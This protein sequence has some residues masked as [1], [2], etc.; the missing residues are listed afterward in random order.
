MP[1]TMIRKSALFFMRYQDHPALDIGA[2]L[3]G[4]LSLAPKEG[5]VALSLLTGN[6]TPVS[7]DE[8]LVL[9]RIS[10]KD[11]V[12]LEET[13]KRLEIGRPVFTQLLERALLLDDGS[14]HQA[15][16]NKERSY[17]A[18]DWDDFAALYHI[19][20]R[21][22]DMD[23]GAPIRGA[24]LSTSGAG[25]T[26]EERVDEYSRLTTHMSASLASVREQFGPA[27]PPFHNRARTQ[28]RRELPLP[29]EKNQFIELLKQRKT[30]RIFDDINPL[31]EHE[32]STILYYTYGCQG[33]AELLPGVFG[34]RKTSPS[35]GSLHPIEAYP[36]VVNVA[37]VD[38]GLYHYNVEHHTLDLIRRMRPNQAADR[39]E[40]F[41]LGQSYFRT[42]NV[43][44][45]LTARW[46][47][48]FWKYRKAQKSYR[49]VYTDAGHLSQTLY[50]LCT[51]MKLGAFFTGAIN[52]INIEE[53]LGL[54]PLEEGV[55]GI[56]GCGRP[57]QG[58]SN[59]SLETL[60]YTPRKTTIRKGMTPQST[61]AFRELGS[62]RHRSKG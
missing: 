47:R 24:E 52:D 27:P 29:A 30:V 22:K 60:P 59:L 10:T 37:G 17:L 23:V 53:E 20:S 44:F 40:C 50:L 31:N 26:S 62:S 6:T 28:E 42:A 25:A 2:M 21:M 35:G 13:S 3:R 16:R 41:S 32:L 18:Q 12:S 43:L 58:G 33:Y 38:S 57:W 11:W 19:T 39:A 61:G 9:S 7:D 8:F 45:I 54:D 34:L 55:I 49:V 36:L 51:E 48:H 14:A 56:S 1:D 15:F 5:L 4:T 46:Y